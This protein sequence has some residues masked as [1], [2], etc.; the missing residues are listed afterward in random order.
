MQR[1]N[2]MCLLKTG[3]RMKF[4]DYSEYVCIVE[5]TNS[6]FDHWFF[7]I[8][9]LSNNPNVFSMKKNINSLPLK[10]QTEK[11]INLLTENN[12]SY[13]IVVLFQKRKMIE[14]MLFNNPKDKLGLRLQLEELKEQ[15]TQTTSTL[16]L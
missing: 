6:I 9:N 13:E 11:I 10:D 12:A 8:R 7:Q 4:L 15:C 3:R 5:N 2:F 1:R 14:E 16:R